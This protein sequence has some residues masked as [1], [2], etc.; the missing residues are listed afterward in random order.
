M[1]KTNRTELKFA[2]TSGVA[3]QI[4]ADIAKFLT[5]DPHARDAENDSKYR[6]RSLYFESSN[7][8]FYRE[9]LAGVS[10]RV[11][12]RI[13]T[14]FPL[15]KENKIFLEIKYKNNARQK[16][17]R[18]QISFQEYCLLLQGSYSDLLVMREDDEVLKLFINFMLKFGARPR[19]CVDYCRKPYLSTFKSHYMRATFD[20]KISFHYSTDLFKN[21]GNF[22]HLVDQKYVILELKFE[23][24]I[25]HWMHAII[26]KYNLKVDAL[27]KYALAARRLLA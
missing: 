21:T 15:T 19:L 16:K 23:N 11:K 14:Y 2:V 13:R 3:P 18:S 6:I 17:L 12:L 10:E 8:Y 5:L 4:E 9:K 27:S 20:S 24:N 26:I 22:Q 25:P 1:E 7:N